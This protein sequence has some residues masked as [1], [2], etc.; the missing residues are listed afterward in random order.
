MKQI[1]LKIKY[2]QKQ[3][4]VFKDDARFKVL[5]AGR[6]WGKG[7]GAVNW[8]VE[9]TASDKKG[10]VSW[11]IAPTYA[12]TKL[13][14]RKY[15]SIIRIIMATENQ[16]ELRIILINGAEVFFKSAD[17]P[18]N[19]RGEK[20]KRAVL[21]EC[22]TM[23]SQVWP[24]IIR[25]ML[26]DS[27][28]EA[29]FTSTPKGKNW[30][31]NIFAKGQD[32]AQT[33]YKSWKFTSYEN[34]FLSKLEIDAAAK[35]LP[36]RVIRQEIMAEFIDDVGSVF[37]GVD[38]CIGGTLEEP[39]HGTGYIMGVDLGKYDDFTVL[40]CIDRS[41]NHV[42][43][44]DRFN[45]VTWKLQEQRILEMARKYQATVF[46]DQ[47]QV[48]DAVLE[49][50]KTKW[51]DITGIRFTNENKMA[52]VNYLS[53]LIE[54]QEISY[55]EIPEL[56]NELKTF[57]FNLTRGGKLSAT[58]VIGCHD[59]CVTALMLATYNNSQTS[60]VMIDVV[61]DEDFYTPERKSII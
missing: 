48:G 23:K 6:R 11:W 20:L 16:S 53:S 21:D 57:E 4:E 27:R 14:Y 25:P 13:F 50:I 19:L 36:E 28:G 12:Q 51:N 29:V 32:S 1:N 9:K 33:E 49:S 24:E 43:A 5:C 2:H 15:R 8:L 47:G 17:N 58:A 60:P 59:D 40:V 18:D 22:A 3:H 54:K 10:D 35:D 7:Y 46:I 38:G 42:V 56:Q 55:P 26:M 52:M 45:T 61:V 34:P 41:N 39:K 31:F 44:F 30:F 37:R